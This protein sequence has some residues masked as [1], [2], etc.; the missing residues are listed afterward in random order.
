MP[1]FL[2]QDSAGSTTEDEPIEV[3]SP[4]DQRFPQAATVRTAGDFIAVEH[5]DRLIPSAGEDF[6]L[7]SWIKP[8]RL[9][10]EEAE[11]I[12]LAKIEGDRAGA[13]GFSLGLVQTGELVRP[14]LYWRDANGE[15]E[16][17]LFSEISLAAKEWL[18]LGVGVVENKLLTVYSALP[19]ADGEYKL[20]FHGSHELEQEVI[21]M[22][23][24]DFVIGSKRSGNF[25]GHLG[26]FGIIAGKELKEDFQE[27]FSELL[28]DPSQF[29]ESVEKEQVRL[30]VPETVAD[31]S[32]YG[33]TVKVRGI[34]E[35]GEKSKKDRSK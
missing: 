20:N 11:T 21:P 2:N 10:K 16:G 22:T 33:H 12:F 24:T 5:S 19:D 9:P 32:S 28:E 26:P 7:F 27:I 4:R 25:R 14:T 3:P 35:F 15:G 13:R 23:S 31:L 30:F 6:I 34:G 18:F 8:R 29:P 1:F 17:F